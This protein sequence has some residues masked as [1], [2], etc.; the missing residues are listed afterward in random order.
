MINVIVFGGAGFLGSHVSDVLTERGYSVFIFDRIKSD[1][2][3]ENQ[4]MI[5]GDILNKN[6]VREAV[7]NASVVYHFAAMADIQDA[8]DNPVAAANYNIM[9]TM[10]I[11]DAC[12]EFS[13]KRFVYSSTIYVYSDH[14]SFYRSTKQACE[15]FIE[16][17]H[18]EYSLNFTILR[19]G[20]LYGSRANDFNFIH[21]CIRQALIEGKIVRKGDGEEIREYVNIVDAAKASVDAL[22]EDYKN[23]YLMITGAQ[24]MKVKELLMMIKEILNDEIEVEYINEELQGHYK[25]TP[26][27]FKPKVA[28]KIAP[29]DYYDLGQGIL[30]SIY[31]IYQNLIS[32]GLITPKINMENNK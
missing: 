25:I 27:S 15:L 9:G 16:N 24:T 7:R 21:N 29:K 3:G 28:L 31:E 11:L 30:D 2:L 12:R 4:T 10:N 18:K 20:S 14:G 19:F 26:Y 6:Q 8:R 22:N 13:I 23:S 32:E 17:Y 5:I 1:Y